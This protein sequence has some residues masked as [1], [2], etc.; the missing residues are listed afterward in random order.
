MS[1]ASVGVLGV[2][3]A[4]SC[5]AAQAG[6]GQIPQQR[7]NQLGLSGLC[8]AADSPSRPASPQP[9]PPAGENPAPGTYGL[10]QFH[11]LMQIDRQASLARQAW[12]WAHRSIQF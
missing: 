4:L 11:A 10:R 2:W 9:V 3:M 5:A 8:V 6:D 12:L 7:L 1:R